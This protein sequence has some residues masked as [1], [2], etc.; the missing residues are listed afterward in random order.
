MTTHTSPLSMASVVRLLYTQNPFY[1]IGTLL[2]L[3]GLQQSLGNQPALGSSGLLVA[4]LAGYALLLAGLAT[5]IIRGGKVWDDARTILLVIVLLFF[6]L[7]SSLD[8]HILHD[9][10]AGTLMLI[11]G[12]AF[13]VALSEGLLRG[14]GIHLAA[15]YRG[16]YYLML[17]LLFGYPIVLAWL[18]FYDHYVLLSWALF[19]FATLAALVLLTL[20]PAASTPAQREPAS[21][22]PWRWPYYPWSLFV[23]LTIGVA[24]RAWWLTIAFQPTIGEDSCFRA[25]YLAPLIIAWSALLLEFGKARASS[26]ALATGMLLPLVVVPLGFPGPALTT[27]E[28]Q[29]VTRLMEMIGS[30]AQLAISSLLLFYAWAGWRRVPGAEAFLLGLTGLLAVVGRHTVDPQTLVA[31]QPAIVAALVIGLL[32]Q[33]LRRASSWRALLAGGLIAAGLQSYHPLGVSPAFWFWQ[34]HAP[35]LGALWLAAIFDDPAAQGWRQLAWRVVPCLAAVAA[36]IYPWTMPGVPEAVIVS[37]GALL[38]ISAA[39]LWWRERTTAAL[40]AVFFT[41]GANLLGQV[42]QV[43][44]LLEQTL[45]AEGLPWLAGGLV[46]VALAFGISLLKMGLWQRGHQWLQQTN[47][48]WGGLG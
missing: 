15:Q 24:L 27:I 41:L 42:R 4:M 26:G 46:V 9:P 43:Y 45:L 37:Y 17:S 16:P 21:G 29:F 12:L 13:A 20:L 18:S 35:V 33:S 19:I 10:L 7:S 47:V 5:I 25:Y 36:T 3:L 38:L 1:L 28:H 22:T 23:F 14:L 2:V 32:V 34:W 48:A 39:A 11:G 31:P 6:M 8:V 30:P 40:G 44:L